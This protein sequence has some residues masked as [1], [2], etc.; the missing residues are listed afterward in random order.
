MCA[1]PHKLL[2][3]L[4]LKEDK[5][6]YLSNQNNSKKNSLKYNFCSVKNIF[7]WFSVGFDFKALLYEYDDIKACYET[8]FYSVI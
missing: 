5:K 6:N 1:C 3:I 4:K 8:H 7:C 2:E